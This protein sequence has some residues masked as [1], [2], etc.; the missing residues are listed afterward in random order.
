MRRTLY[1]LWMQRHARFSP[2]RAAAETRTKNR[3]YVPGRKRKYQKT[4]MCAITAAACIVP[5]LAIDS[6]TIHHIVPGLA[7]DSITIHH[8]VPGLAMDSVAARHTAP[9][10]A[11]GTERTRTASLC[12]PRP[13]ESAVRSA[14]HGRRR[15]GM[16]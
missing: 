1:S 2:H 6:I 7:I 13:N 5:G 8:I 14:R 10:L 4:G 3:H 16:P 11:T 15:Q 9:G 12:S